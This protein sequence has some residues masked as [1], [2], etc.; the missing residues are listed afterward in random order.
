M[1]V[2]RTTNI[3]FL[4]I[5]KE[6]KPPLWDVCIETRKKR[7]PCVTDVLIDCC[8]STPKVQEYFKYY[9]TKSYI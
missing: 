2:N 1:H 7:S 3:A 5:G 4:L 9:K 6:S 8:G